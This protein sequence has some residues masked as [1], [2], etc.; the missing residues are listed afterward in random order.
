MDDVTRRTREHL[1][2]EAASHRKAAEEER[3]KAA[4]HA[5]A[6]ARHEETA[7][8]AEDLLERVGRDET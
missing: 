7:R 1:R 5:G 4:T 2:A 3:A 6:A 8:Q